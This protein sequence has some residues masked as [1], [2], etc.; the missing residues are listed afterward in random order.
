MKKTIKAHL[1]SMYG[2]GADDVED[3][4]Q[5]GVQTVRDCLRVL[6]AEYARDMASFAESMH[7]LKGALFNMGLEG[8]GNQARVLELAGKNGEAGLIRD[9]YPAFR[10]E[11]CTIR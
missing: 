3:L 4:Y 5:L 8:L 6:D 1:C 9:T 7:T 11:V 10:D 2:L